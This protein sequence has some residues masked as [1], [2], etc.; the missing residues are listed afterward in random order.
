M[1]ATQSQT[2]CNLLATAC[3]LSR[4][5]CDIPTL[6]LF[7]SFCCCCT[8]ADPF[9]AM[10]S[11][12]AA[13]PGCPGNSLDL[14]LDPLPLDMELLNQQGHQSMADGSM[15]PQVQGLPPQL[16]Q[17]LPAWGS[18]WLPAPNNGFAHGHLPQQQQLLLQ[19]TLQQM[20]LGVGAGGAP[21]QAQAPF[22]PLSDW[23]LPVKSPTSK[24]PDELP[25]HAA[26]P[27]SAGVPHQALLGQAHAAAALAGSG[28]VVTEAQPVASQAAAV[29]AAAEQVAPQEKEQALPGRQRPTSEAAARQTRA[30][31]WAPAAKEEAQGH[32]PDSGGPADPN[33]ACARAK[34]EEE[35]LHHSGG[36]GGS[37]S[38]KGEKL[39]LRERNRIA[40]R[41]FRE[42]S[43]VRGWLRSGWSRRRGLP[44][45][46]M[47]GAGVDLPASCL[48]HHH[49]W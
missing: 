3:Q 1:Y 39:T 11:Q 27:P 22:M 26:A 48:W 8:A 17:Q 10:L 46:S 38:G 13:S 19:P 31:G 32:E 30:Q 42:R 37:G 41:R 43:R 49:D 14:D 21:W 47:L 6:L 24:P 7:L 23:C 9:D 16:P 12:L 20:V 29:P 34:S 36:S 18:G 45:Q 35:P 5:M 44:L 25:T 2:S 4:P 15:P 40:Q 33:P 28:H